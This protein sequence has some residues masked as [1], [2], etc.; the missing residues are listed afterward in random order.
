MLFYTE[1]IINDKIYILF[2]KYN[3]V[4]DCE[5]K[6]QFLMPIQ[7]GLIS[8]ILTLKSKGTNKLQ[9]LRS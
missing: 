9:C 6:L 4:T 2:N 8:K 1:I 3:L 5:Y 7:V